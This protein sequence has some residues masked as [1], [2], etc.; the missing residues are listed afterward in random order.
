MS[1]SR[2]SKR[3]TSGSSPAAAATRS[4]LKPGMWSRRATLISSSL[5]SLGSERNPPTRTH[6]LDRASQWPEELADVVG[7]EIGLLEGGEVPAAGHHGP[8][9]DVEEVLG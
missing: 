1:V 8:A 7:E 5:L 3:S 6:V 4:M 9:G 2:F